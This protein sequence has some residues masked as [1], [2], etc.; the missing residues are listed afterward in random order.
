MTT[1]ISEKT[2]DDTSM[3]ILLNC[4]HILNEQ[5]INTRLGNIIRGKTGTLHRFLSDTDHYGLMID[6][7]Q[8]ANDETLK[9]CVRNKNDIVKIWDKADKMSSAEATALFQSLYNDKSKSKKFKFF[10]R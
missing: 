4:S 9:I 6:C 5:E 1:L 3:N 10:R 7:Y 8:E 2:F